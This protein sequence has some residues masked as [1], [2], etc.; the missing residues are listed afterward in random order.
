MSIRDDLKRAV[1]KSGKSQNQIA[2]DTG[3]DQSTIS[4]FL[5]G[6]HDMGVAKLEK[7]VAYLGMRVEI[8]QPEKPRKRK[9]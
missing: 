1:E 8:H 6:R 9:G 3:I 4:R 5:A 2:K 7:L